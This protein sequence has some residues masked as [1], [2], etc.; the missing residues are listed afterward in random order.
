MI[1]CDL[2]VNA[3]VK[4]SCTDLQELI[5]NK[6]ERV[7]FKKQQLKDEE[8][9]QLSVEAGIE[10]QKIINRNFIIRFFR[11]KES[12]WARFTDHYLLKNVYSKYGWFGSYD[13]LTK[14]GEESP[15]NI[16]GERILN[17]LNELELCIEH[18]EEPYIWINSSI[19]QKIC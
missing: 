2:D 17:I 4:V 5:N 1:K 14:Y 7:L 9:E 11:R 18:S 16:Y 15:A 19:L 6:K 3:L 10:R 12:S 8:L 13:F